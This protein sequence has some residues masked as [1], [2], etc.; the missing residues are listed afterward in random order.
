MAL[1]EKKNIVKLVH[2]VSSLFS[3]LQTSRLNPIFHQHQTFVIFE[4]K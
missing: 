4:K 2:F 3:L 1:Y